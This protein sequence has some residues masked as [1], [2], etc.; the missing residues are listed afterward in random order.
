MIKLCAFLFFSNILS[1]DKDDNINISDFYYKI[2]QGIP[3]VFDET[4][5][6]TYYLD[7]KNSSILI[8]QKLNSVMLDGS[9]SIP[10]GS[11]YLPKILNKS[12]NAD[13]VK[14]ISQIF[15]R[16]GDY[17][18]S[19]LGIGLQIESTD[20]LRFIYRGFKRSQPQIYQVG[21]DQLQNHIFSID[22]NSRNTSMYIE[23]LYHYEELTLPLKIGDSGREV[24]SF[25]GGLNFLTNFDRLVLKGLQAYQFTYLDQNNSKS[26]NLSL[27]NFISGRF[28]L[29]NNISASIEY[30]FKKHFIEVEEELFNTPYQFVDTYLEYSDSNIVACFGGSTFES[31]FIPTT[32]LLLKKKQYY[33]SFVRDFNVFL[34]KNQ[35]FQTEAVNKIDNSFIIGYEGLKHKAKVELF[36]I[37]YENKSTIGLTFNSFI[38]LKWLNFSHKT[39]FLNLN[40]SLQIQPVNYYSKTSFI[41]SPDTWFWKNS[42][43]QPF[44]GLQSVYLK[45]SGDIGL[46]PVNISLFKE[47]SEDFYYP[48]SNLVNLEVGLL[49]NQFKLSYKWRNFSFSDNTI[50]NSVNQNIRPIASIRHFEI[51]WQFWN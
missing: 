35:H 27:W 1:Q 24:E 18:F 2:E 3:I 47:N 10:L 6:S 51:I 8:D 23:T 30:E 34:I 19:D 31:S 13:S 21:L 29:I 37:I 44:V 26:S 50:Q 36:N 42:R 48:F 20:S 9:I 25:H 28:Q 38:K 11:Y 5:E 46:D 40:N 22:R 39:G 12:L 33:I 32:K 45:H 4:G 43:Y 16:K 14:N 7:E 49:V 41:F 15:Y 17:D